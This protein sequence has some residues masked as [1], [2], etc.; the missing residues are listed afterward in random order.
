MSR[1]RSRPWVGF[2]VTA[3]V[4]VAVVS[5]LTFA[6]LRLDRDEVHARTQAALHERL[7]LALWRM[8]SWLSPQ[9]ARESMRPPSEYRAFPA[10]TTAWTRGLTKIG[11]DEVVVQSPLL[12]VDAPLFPLHFEIGPDGVTS[13]Q[14]PLGNER[15][16]CEGTGIEA[17][18]LDRAAERLRAFASTLQRE[19]LEQKLG[20]IETALPLLGCNA[21]EPTDPVATQQSVQELSNRQRNLFR[22]PAN[23]ANQSADAGVGAPAAAM[24]ML[25]GDVGPMVPVWLD[26][27]GGQLV[28]VRRVREGA[29][30]RL[31]GVLVDWPTMQRELIAL[32]ADLFSAPCISLVRCEAPTASQQPSMLASV[33][34]R[35]DAVH[36][37]PL[38]SGL[39][40]PIVLATTWGV[41]LLGLG[42]LWFTLRAAIGYGE[43]RARFASAVTHELRTPLTT[44]RMYSEMLADGVV[45]EPDAQ[46][47]YLTTL[48]RESDRLARVVENVLAWSRLEEGRFT[49]RRVAHEVG[50]L[51]D[52]LAPTLQRRL[53]EAGM[54]L[55]VDVA[56][57]VRSRTLVTDEDA[58][59]QILFNLVDNAAKYARGAS[60]PRV[61]IAAAL[62]GGRA[63]FTV[64][65]HGPGVPAA[66]HDRVF[67]PFDRGAVAAGNNEQ[68]GVGL[69]LALAR[70]LAR[71]LGGDL[72]LGAV[73]GPGAAF[74]LEL[75]LA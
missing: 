14:V 39:P 65:D 29:G 8:D 74:R 62:E 13:P 16:L 15:D 31:Q 24:A 54:T 7:R 3:A 68:P 4:L 43:R 28:F 12:T 2:L 56:A 69:G 32:I 10:A 75:P 67:A 51:L 48:Q 22:N 64:R 70:G 73:D 26:G 58:V 35:L 46:R 52:R 45:K 53:Q 63:V 37:G 72:R 41:T 21:I 49:A 18:R 25:A 50:P 66:H 6:L 36:D 33:P 55:V 47:E 38:A 71:D 44:F 9:L 34:A 27:G 60:D 5:W 23:F 57:G 11:A 1:A 42:V 40:L 17:A 61:E 19:V 20:V 30:S 59:G